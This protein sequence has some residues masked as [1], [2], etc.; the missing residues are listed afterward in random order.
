M[1]FIACLMC[2]K[3]WTIIVSYGGATED[4]KLATC[5]PYNFGF[6]YSIDLFKMLSVSFQFG[7]VCVCLTRTCRMRIWHVDLVFCIRV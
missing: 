4:M 6:T 3:I 7:R 2:K 1:D 5:S